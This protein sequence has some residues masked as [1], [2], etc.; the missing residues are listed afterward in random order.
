MPSSYRKVSSPITELIGNLQSVDTN[1]SEAKLNIT[2]ITDNNGYRI[3]L[4][5]ENIIKK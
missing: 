2:S 4:N 3:E 5:Q 1:S